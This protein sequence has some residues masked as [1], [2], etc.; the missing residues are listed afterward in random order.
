MFTTNLVLLYRAEIRAG[1]MKKEYCRKTLEKD[2][3]RGALRVA[4]AYDT[5]S[6]DAVFVIAIVTPISVLAT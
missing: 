2:Q 4:S 6:K 1:E 3:R 5:V